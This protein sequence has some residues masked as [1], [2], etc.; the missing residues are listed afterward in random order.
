VIAVFLAA[1]IALSDYRARLERIDAQLAAGDREHAARGARTLLQEKVRAGGEEIAPDTR[2][3]EPIAHG[4]PRRARLRTLI[5][6]LPASLGEAKAPDRALLEDLRR[7]QESVGPAAG[8]DLEP[9]NAPEPPLWQELLEG[10]EQGLRW[11]GD[12]LI[13]LLHWIED[14]FPSTSLPRAGVAGRITTLV[15]VGVG[16]I[17]VLVAALALLTRHKPPS[18][19][20][21]ARSRRQ[22]AEDEDPLSRTATGWE[23]YAAELAAQGRARQ[24]IRAWYHALLVRCYGAGVLHYHRGRTNW[25]YV[26]ALSPSL[27]WRQSFWELTRSFD[28]EWYGHAEST[29]EALDAFAGEARTVLRALGRSP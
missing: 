6:S 22:A 15:L 18:R 24:A 21:P 7:A 12:R 1:S 14:L 29:P 4:K 9:I 26:Q 17:V 19:V 13:D 11:L 28:L 8:G 23:A 5:D 3:L 10:L 20:A 2:A 16:F 25:E 27:P